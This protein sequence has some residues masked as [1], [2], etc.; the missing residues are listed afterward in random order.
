MRA[1]DALRRMLDASGTSQYAASKRMGKSVTYVQTTLK[2]NT[3]GAD[4]LAEVAAVCGYR[5]VLIPKEGGD[6]IEI[7][8]I[9][10]TDGYD[11]IG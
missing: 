4:K 5:L 2:N 1:I 3:M 8:S 7:G 11:E 9:E 6:E 10:I